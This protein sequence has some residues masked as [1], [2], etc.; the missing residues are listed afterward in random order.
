MEYRA[1]YLVVFNQP[2]QY[3]DDENGDRY[4]IEASSVVEAIGKA[5]IRNPGLRYV[6]IID[7]MEC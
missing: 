3:P 1:T 5:L 4:Y 6:D 2:V 7:H